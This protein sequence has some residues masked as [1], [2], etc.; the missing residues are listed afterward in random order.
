MSP[1]TMAEINVPANA[2]V[3]MVPILRKKFAW[4]NAYQHIV[5]NV[6]C[7][8]YSLDVAHSPMRG[9]WVAGGG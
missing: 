6:I 8:K 9:L 3:R 5:Q 7:R 4:A 2:K 1:R